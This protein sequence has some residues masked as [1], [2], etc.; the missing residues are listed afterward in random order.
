MNGRTKRMEVRTEKQT[1]R[2]M[3]VCTVCTYQLSRQAVYENTFAR[4][5]SSRAGPFYL[6]VLRAILLR[7]FVYFFKAASGQ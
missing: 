1:D 4:P 6:H 3:E 7:E 2:G 5:L